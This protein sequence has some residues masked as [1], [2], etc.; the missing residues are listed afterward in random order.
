[1]SSPGL[2][3]GEKSWGCIFFVRGCASTCGGVA[4]VFWAFGTALGEEDSAI[5]AEDDASRLATSCFLPPSLA[6]DDVV[7]VVTKFPNPSSS[8]GLLLF[9]SSDG[10]GIGFSFGLNFFFLSLVL[11]APVVLAFSVDV[12]L[13]SFP[14]VPAASSSVIMSF[15]S[16]PSVVVVVFVVTKFP[17]PNSSRG[18]LSFK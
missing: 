5:A 7:V 13:V 8:R 1:M 17:N 9:R 3:S 10:D 4:A 2:S 15:F 14:P 6:D 16:S 11:F 18:L 12:L